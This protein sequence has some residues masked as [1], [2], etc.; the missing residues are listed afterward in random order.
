MHYSLPLK[1]IIFSFLALF[2]LFFSPPSLSKVELKNHSSQYLQKKTVER[3]ICDPKN[4]ICIKYVTTGS[5]VEAEIFNKSFE[6][7]TV[8]VKLWHNNV[9]IELAVDNLKS[10]LLKGKETKPLL[11]LEQEDLSR[12]YGYNFT[13]NSVIG[14]IDA[15]HDDNY[16]YDL[17]FET[18]KSYTL[19]QGYGGKFSH[20]NEQNYY[21]YDFR[22]PIGQTITAAR[23]GVVIAVVE[24]YR[25]GGIRP[26]MR[27]KSNYIY[28]EHPDNT[29]AIYSHLKYNGAIVN[30]GDHVQ[31]GQNIA[32]SGNTGYTDT[33]H[34]HFS[35]VKVKKG[36][37]MQSLPIKI[38]T[39]EGALSKLDKFNK[40]RKP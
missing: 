27:N 17:P 40:Y 13:F 26:K 1:V 38:K 33:P 37:K 16:I 31:K 14:K 21:S 8:E 2:Y 25:L 5:K 15:V 39:E 12:S 4:I 7:R 29:I 18:G 10:I 6:S 23:E 28:I 35:V 22:M 9:K 19:I 24:G 3:V 32:Y 11:K 34:L 20:N 36:G 30:V